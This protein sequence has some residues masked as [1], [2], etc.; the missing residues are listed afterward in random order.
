MRATRLACPRSLTMTRIQII[1]VLLLSRHIVP[2]SS[3]TTDTIS[4]G[5]ALTIRDKL[6]SENGRYALGFFK[7]AG[8]KF[9]Q[10]TSS[11]H[12][13]IWFNSIPK[14]TQ[15]WVANRDNPIQ[16]SISLE[17]K[18]SQDG[19]LV[20]LNASTNS[21]IWSTQAKITSN[22]TNATILNSGNLILRNASNSSDILWQSFDHPTDT[23]LPGA[24]LGWDKFS[25]LNRRLVS[26]KNSISLAT[27][28]YCEELDPSGV[29]QFVLAA[30]HSSAP[31]WFSGL[32]NGQ[33]FGTV[34]EI[35]SHQMSNSTFVDNDEQKYFT[36]ELLSETFVVRLVLDVSGQE[37]AFIWFQGAQDWS[38]VYS[39]PRSQCDVYAACGPFTICNDDATPYCACME[40][41]TIKSPRDWE[42]DDRTGGCLRNTPLDCVA[43]GSI[44]NSTDK[45]YS[46]TCVSLPQSAHKIEAKSIGECAQVCLEN[47]SCTAY[48]FGNG[49]CSVWHEELLNIRQVQCSSS[50]NSNGETLYLRIANKDV[51]NLQKNKSRFIIGLA[52]GTSVAA[53]GLFAFIMLILI[54]RKRRESSARRSTGAQGYNGITVFR[55]TDLQRIT[56]NFS[57]KLGGGGFGSVFKGFL[58]NS[59]AVA[60]KRLDCASQGEKQFRMEVSS[61]G[62][63]QHINLVKL[64]GFCC[65]GSRRL[66]VYEHMPNRSLDIHLF[67]SHAAVLKWSTRYQIA[68]GV[69]RGLAYLHEYC[70]DCIIH[71][72][73]KPENI[74]LG[75][76][77]VP[78]VADF[79][80]AKF[81][82]RDFSR[83]LTTVRGTIGYL[84]PEWISGTAITSKVDVYAYGMVLLEIISGRRNSY[85]PC[86]CGRS[87]DICYAVH[88]AR[89]TLEGDVRSLVD[90]RLYD[91]VNLNE[92]EIACKVACWCIQD[93][94]LDR[95]TMGKVVQILEGLLEIN[96]PP[97]P[98]LLQ[99]ITGSSHS[100]YS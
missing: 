7:S 100:T 59:I 14:F 31:Y 35:A 58:N 9:S 42:L 74:L 36:Y 79:G 30:L 66:L 33:S 73:I 69:A 76:S 25:G 63:I 55:Y 84:A 89:K 26:S 65:D 85:V 90:H 29:S 21:V 82:G 86:S 32:W 11:W 56:K 37:K 70:R 18:F 61:I 27:G 45:F 77:F 17:L 87:H 67:H 72:D 41:F 68:L 54:W 81:L 92:V 23:L 97:M 53:L 44:T 94:E 50:T 34:P 12:L 4:A 88:A 2:A 52:I 1:I 13:G 98:R 78:K 15:V 5:Q 62:I 40:G 16:S 93:D 64:V 8:Y 22:N 39:K 91:D 57:E 3:A 10:N 95:P 71:C 19:N 96:V 51:H 80:M 75:D 46:L 43:N 6:V 20:I 47:C 38:M 24:K 28:L 99:V 49:R 48:S 83:V 60:V